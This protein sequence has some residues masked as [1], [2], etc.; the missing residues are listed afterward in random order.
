MYFTKDN[1]VSLSIRVSPKQKLGQG[2]E[3]WGKRFLKLRKA[4]LNICLKFVMR[5]AIW[6]HLYHLK[7]VKNT[8]LQ[9]ATLRKLTLLHG[10]FSRFLNCTNGTKSRNV[11]HLYFVNG[12]SVTEIKW[13]WLFCK[14]LYSGKLYNVTRK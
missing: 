10:C 4:C 6:Y 2:V 5:F 12:C 3:E 11:P 1:E 8:Q 14:N 13:V 7:N 9:S